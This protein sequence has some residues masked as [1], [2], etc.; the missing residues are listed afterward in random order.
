M[1]GLDFLAIALYGA[2][3]LALGIGAGRGHQSTAEL[4]LG[5]RRL[6]TWAVG[7]STVATELSAATFIGVPHAAYTGDWSYLQLAFGALAAK[8]LI[9]RRVIP[10]YYRLRVVTVY[11]FLE[12]RFGPGARLACA[13]CF[14]GGRVLA[15]GVRLFIAALA[16]SVAAGVSLEAAIVA[17]GAVA[18]VYTLVGGIRAVVWTDVLQGA[19]FV[20]AAGLLLAAVTAAAPG[21]LAGLLDWAGANGRTQVFHVAPWLALSDGRSVA[22]AF[23]GGFFLTL[24]TH[25][26]DHDMV[27]RLL[28]TRDGRAGAR[29]LVGSALA[30]FPLTALFLAIGTGLAHFYATPHAYPPGDPARILPTFAIHELPSGARGLVFAGLFAAAMSS[31]DSAVCALATTWITD[32]RP[33]GGDDAS[34]VVRLRRASLVFTLLLI[35]AALGMAA[36]HRALAERA[37]AAPVSLVDLALSAMTVLYGGLLGVFAVGLAGESRGSDASARAGLAAGAVVGLALF[38][39]P[40]VLGGTWIAWAWWIPIGAAVTALVVASAPR[41]Q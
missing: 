22:T 18:G 4:V 27:Q 9:A 30:N 39:H 40:V 32:I 29:A 33:A 21:G 17:C 38:V 6:P 34:S 3:V 25:T 15:S 8:L 2:A 24:A 5:G 23:A 20:A 41:P 31:L 36:Y 10:L 7:L 11:G 35:G 12:G 37:G 14:T 26:T 16:F 13:L 1:D 28:T 19:V